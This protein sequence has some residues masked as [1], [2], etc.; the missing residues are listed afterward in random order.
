MCVQDSRD[1]GRAGRGRQAERRESGER[2]RHTR[3]IRED[4]RER[5]R[6]SWEGEIGYA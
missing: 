1:C 6:E 3:T 5:E 2:R 4:F